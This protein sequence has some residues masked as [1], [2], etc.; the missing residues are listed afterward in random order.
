M[1]QQSQDD[2]SSDE[3]REGFE[4]QIPLVENFV[5][6]VFNEAKETVF[7][8][9]VD[10]EPRYICTDGMLKYFWIYFRKQIAEAS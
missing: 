4:A 10:Y 9:P 1:R 6:N 2:C 7:N 5:S 8:R 3:G